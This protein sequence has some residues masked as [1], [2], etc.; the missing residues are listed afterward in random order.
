MRT[1]HLVFFPKINNLSNHEK[2]SDKLKLRDILQNT[3]PVLFTSIKVMK[4][5]EETEK[6]T[7]WRRLRKT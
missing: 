5:Q 7:D 3:W 6:L 1:C 2:K 4:G